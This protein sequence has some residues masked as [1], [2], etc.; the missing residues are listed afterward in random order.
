[1]LENCLSDHLRR[2]FATSTDVITAPTSEIQL[3]L[4][5]LSVGLIIFEEEFTI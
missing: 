2:P 1:M 3:S 5:S 4:M